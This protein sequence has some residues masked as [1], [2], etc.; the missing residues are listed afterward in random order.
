MADEPRLRS[1]VIPDLIGLIYDSVGD[2]SRWPAFLEAFASAVRTPCC[3]LLIHN[4]ESD[5]FTVVRWHGW[6]DQDI[7]LYFDRY[8]PIDPL[9]L[10]T[11][12]SPEGTVGSDYEACPR[13][14]FEASAAFREFY[15]PRD[16]IHGMGGVILASG[17]G[18]SVITAQRGR[19]EGPFGEEEKS[20]LRQ[21]MPHLKRAALLHG[22]LGSLR[23]E[24]ATFTGHLERYPYAFL[25]IDAERHVLYSNAAAREILLARDGLGIGNGRFSAISPKAEV[26][27]SKAVDELGSGQSRG[28]RR[29]EILRPSRRKSYR[30]LL[31]PIHDARPILPLSVAVPAISVLVV[32]PESASSPDPEVL[33]ELFSLTPAEARVSVRLVQGQSAAEIA[34]ETGTSAETVRTH[35]KRILSK[36]GTNRQGELISL[37]LRSTRFRI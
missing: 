12:R 31:M 22:E 21:L 2:G 23:R 29:M 6:L 24:V 17:T 11:A 18:Q 25:L 7:Q 33:R 28:L 13:E 35:L 19:K 20:I 3:A 36:T 30:V 4:P 10:G 8:G 26:A 27:L 14:E 34:A 37:I 1:A 32:D 15:A 9:R 5:R 16:C